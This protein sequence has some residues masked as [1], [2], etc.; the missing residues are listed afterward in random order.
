LAVG[1]SLG[2]LLG[3]TLV[4]VQYRVGAQARIEG[5][6]QRT[7]VAPADGFLS[8]VH[9]R[10]GDRVKADQV[11][12]ELAADDLRLEQR[13]W[14]SELTQHENAASAAL[15]RTDRAQFVINQS[16]ADEARAQMDLVDSQLTRGRIV[17]PFDGVIIKGDLAQSLGAPLRRGEVLLTIAPVDQYRLVIEVDERDIPAVRV[18]QKGSVALGALSEG[19]LAF[20]V[21]RVTPVATTRDGRN[22]FEV[23]GALQESP[24][25]LRPGLQG[26]AKIEAGQRSLAWIWTHRIWEWLRLALWSAGL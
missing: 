24:A 11:L 1:L 2:L 9:A 5:S 14:H 21:E 22:F 26:V 23:E 20:R 17:A 25:M 7:L 13:K 4:P 16:K 8:K 12:A 10:P 3:L 15:A 18:G 6:I 19:A